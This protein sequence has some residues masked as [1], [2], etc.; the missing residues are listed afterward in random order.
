MEHRRTGFRI[1]ID[2]HVP[3]C[4]WKSRTLSVGQNLFSVFFV[5][6]EAEGLR[7]FTVEKLAAV[8]VAT[9]GVDALGNI[10][11]VIQ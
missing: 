10:A 11:D 5:R 7:E 2:A 4:R 6:A 8:T 9:R 1:H 3:L